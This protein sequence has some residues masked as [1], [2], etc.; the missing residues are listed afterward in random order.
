MVANPADLLPVMAAHFVMTGV[1]VV[2]AHLAAVVVAVSVLRGG[3][4]RTQGQGRGGEQEGENALHR[5]FHFVVFKRKKPGSAVAATPEATLGCTVRGVIRRRLDRRGRRPH[6]QFW[7]QTVLI[8]G[9][10]TSF[11]LGDHFSAF[12]EAEVSTGRYGSA[13]DVMRAAL[14]LLEEREAQLGALRAALQEGEDSGPSTPFDFEAF[15]V[16]KRDAVSR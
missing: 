12:I 10:N 11:S 13:S 4:N 5:A 1:P 7:Y 16:A 8:M 9:K 6:T 2:A 3:R 15:I 14:R